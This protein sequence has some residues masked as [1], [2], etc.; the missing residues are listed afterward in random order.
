GTIE[1]GGVSYPQTRDALG[2]VTGTLM[3]GG[4]GTLQYDAL[5]R[6]RHIE[7]AD[8]ATIDY[9]YRPDGVLLS[10][11]VVCN[12]AL[13][14]EPGKTSFVYD[15]LLLRETYNT[16]GATPVLTGRYFY[17]DEADI[18][19]A[20]D[21]ADPV[22][23]VMR[24]VYFVAD[25]MGSVVGVLDAAGNWLER[26][27]FGL[28]GLPEVEAVDTDAPIL[29]TV[30]GDAAGD[31]RLVFTEPVLPPTTQSA[32]TTIEAGH[33]SY[34]DALTVKAGAPISGTWTADSGSPCGINAPAIRF[35]PDV[36]I[37]PGTAVSVVVSTGGLVD[38]W[39]NTIETATVSFTAAPGVVYL[40]P[41]IGSTASTPSDRSSVGNALAFQG[42]LWDADAGLYLARARV[43]SPRTGA[44]LS[45]D[46]SGFSDSVNAY[47]LARNDSIN[48]R[49]PTGACVWENTEEEQLACWRRVGDFLEVGDPRERYEVF[50]ADVVARR[51][52]RLVSKDA[53]VEALTLFIIYSMRSGVTVKDSALKAAGVDLHQDELHRYM[54]QLLARNFFDQAVRDKELGPRQLMPAERKLADRSVP[55]IALN[56]V[57]RQRE[58][59]R[60][61]ESV[62]GRDIN[63]Y[64][65]GRAR[66]WRTRLGNPV[67]KIIKFFRG[68]AARTNPE[69]PIAANGGDFFTSLGLVHHTLCGDVPLVPSLSEAND[70]CVEGM[71]TSE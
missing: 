7:R 43:L 48:Q 34:D 10:R 8:G 12:G 66:P 67:Y 65:W 29:S 36:A 9:L 5:S 47:G 51:P 13:D 41:P 71:E 39:Q 59:H 20:A 63:R 56:L 21:L 53:D 3:K 45:R 25:R 23:H 6:L 30:C 22:T 11:N 54:V 69:H 28:Y 18:P 61:T 2:N 68:E 38:R 46:P 70:Q 14:C 31:L 57:S 27:R 32:T 15:G 37:P 24:R 26:T 62:L 49:D 52:E 44:F 64:F 50:V 58:A 16:T 33:G 19:V 42:H 1:V 55:E 35:H 4:L 17:A 40:G 60:L